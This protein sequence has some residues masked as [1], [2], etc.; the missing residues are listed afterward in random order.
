[1]SLNHSLQYTCFMPFFI[2]IRVQ[3][4]GVVVRLFRFSKFFFHK[5]IMTNKYGLFLFPIWWMIFIF[6]LVKW[7]IV[8]VFVPTVNCLKNIL[9]VSEQ[10]TSNNAYHWHLR[11]LNSP[12][13]M[14]T[15]YQRIILLVL[16]LVGLVNAQEETVCYGPGSIAASV[17]LTFLLTLLL[18]WA[19]YY[20]KNKRRSKTGKLYC[21]KRADFLK[22]NFFFRV[23]RI[24]YFFP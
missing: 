13:K 16:V 4:L 9:F 15:P 5:I 6:N 19:I 10:R 7:L 3:L 11:R 23:I 20:W 8:N 2:W 24:F 21:F 1:M 12:Q 18:V 17:I 22:E 14:E